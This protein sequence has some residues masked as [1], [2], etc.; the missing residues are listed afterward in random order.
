M[1]K[2]QQSGLNRTTKLRR[3]NSVV[4]FNYNEE[5]EVNLKSV[6]EERI[7]ENQELTSRRDAFKKEAL[8][9]FDA[10]H[11]YAL[12]MLRN[13]MDSDDMTQDTFLRAFRFFNSYEKG[14]NCRAWLFKIMK[15]L[16]INKFRKEQKDEATLSYDDIE[17]F[18]S[19]IK[20]TRYVSDD[21][22][23]NIF[24]KLLDDKMTDALNSLNDDYK[25]IIILCDLEG[26]SYDEI[27]EFLH[28]P[29]GTVRS[30]LHRAR[31]LLHQK[32]SSYAIRR[33]YEVN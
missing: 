3:V 17:N 31:M 11:N 25:I 18:F 20:S 6:S 24:S 4:F 22:Q 30:R 23:H 16:I 5:P 15:N 26:M 9:H 12:K 8:P 7:S 13:K 33:G 2:P 14:T 32:L 10:L 21:L 19:D 1:Y 29:I 28:C 27:A